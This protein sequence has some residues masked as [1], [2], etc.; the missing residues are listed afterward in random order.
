[1]ASIAATASSGSAD[2]FASVSWR[3]VPPSRYVRR[4]STDSYTRRSPDLAT[5]IRLFRATCIAPPRPAIPATI[6]SDVIEV[7]EQ[8]ANFVA[9]FNDR[10]RHLPA[11]QDRNPYRELQ[12]LRF[13]ER[14]PRS[15]RLLIDRG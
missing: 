6:A 5:Y 14:R 2:K 11:R 1:V 15:V 8:H 9:T 7:R 4:T 3:T 12:Q 10:N 13:N